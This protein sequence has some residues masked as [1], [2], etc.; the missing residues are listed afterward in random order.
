MDARRIILAVFVAAAAALAAPA[1]A[2]APRALVALPH[3]EGSTVTPQAFARN[4]ASGD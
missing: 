3:G 2:A 1:S 4:Q